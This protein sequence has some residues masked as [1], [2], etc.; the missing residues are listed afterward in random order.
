MKSRI[1]AVSHDK[2]LLLTVPENGSIIKVLLSDLELSA[3][4]AGESLA[5]NRFLMTK[6]LVSNQPDYCGFVSARWDDRFKSWPTLSDLS[7]QIEI[8]AKDSRQALFAPVTMRV[9]QRQLGYWLKAQ[10]RHHPGMTNLL[11]ELISY[12]KIKFHGRNIRA[13]VL[14]NNF[15]APLSVAEELLSFWQDTFTYLYEKYGLDFPFTYRCPKCGLESL[16]RLD[17]YSRVRHAGFLLERVTTL[18]FLSRPDLVPYF[19]SKGKLQPALTRLSHRFNE[20]TVNP[21]L[22]QPFIS[23]RAWLNGCRGRHEVEL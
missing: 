15:V 8:A 17:R 4:I 16:N 23:L 14:A 13:V 3:E 19:S 10:D 2:E 1:Y 11:Y 12:H 21:V 7:A 6:Q 22:T 5:E 9:S 20:V 18:Y